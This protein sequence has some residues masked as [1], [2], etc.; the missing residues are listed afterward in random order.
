MDI[1]SGGGELQQ[2]EHLVA[3]HHLALGRGDVFANRER[4]AV[5]LFWEPTVVQH[6]IAELADAPGQAHATGVHQ[7]AQR[8]RVGQRRVAWC[9]CIGQQRCDE[10]G[11]ALFLWGKVG[12]FDEAGQFTLPGQVALQ[13]RAQEGVGLPGWIG[14]AFVLGVWRDAGIAA[15]DAAQFLQVATQMGASLERRQAHGLEQ[16]T[17]RAGQVRRAH[18]DQRIGRQG[19]VGSRA[20]QLLLLGVASGITL[21]A[22]AA[23]SAGCWGA[24]G[25]SYGLARSGGSA[26]V[27]SLVSGC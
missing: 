15:D 24:L 9:H 16:V 18:A 10:A 26:H 11:P 5:D 3:K 17:G 20:D 12:G 23:L 19:L 14:K 1:F 22:N 2:L 25:W 7:L 13:Q 8:R 4:R 27:G 6:V 21:L